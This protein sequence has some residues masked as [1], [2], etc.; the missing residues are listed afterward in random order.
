MLQ[1]GKFGIL[2]FG[3][4]KIRIVDRCAFF[5]KIPLQ[6]RWFGSEGPHHS[7]FLGL[8]SHDR[9]RFCARIIIFVSYVTK[10]GKQH[11]IP[12]GPSKADS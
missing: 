9:K 11:G 6:K 1:T 10:G 12:L 5:F 8:T 2:E 7:K 4:P 3:D